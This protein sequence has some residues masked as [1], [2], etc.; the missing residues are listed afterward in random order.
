MT[1]RFV[2]EMAVTKLHALVGWTVC[3]LAMYLAMSVTTLRLALIIHLVAAIA[4]FW[5]ISR[6]YF[7]RYNYFSPLKVAGIFL[8]VVVFMDI[9]VVALIINR[10][11]DMFRSAIGTYIPFT[12]IFLITLLTGSQ[13][14]KRPRGPSA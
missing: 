6:F 13:M 1:G 4:A 14:S 9:V 3:G 11:F 2:R 10:S 5:A 12:S 7:R 8:A